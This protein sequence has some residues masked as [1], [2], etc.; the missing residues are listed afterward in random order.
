LLTGLAKL[1]SN[2]ERQLADPFGEKKT[3]WLSY[4]L[5]III[6][7]GA[8]AYWQKD[9]FFACKDQEA[10]QTAPA[11]SKAEP[12]PASPASAAPAQ[13]YPKAA[14]PAPAATDT[15]PKPPAVTETQPKPPAESETK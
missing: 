4:L 6:I 3:Q 15:P 5:L 12:K 14:E 1:P 13:A 9:Y 10:A 2:A 7:A 8:V 11:D